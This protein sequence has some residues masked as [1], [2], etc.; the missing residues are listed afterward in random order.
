LNL[1]CG[2]SKYTNPYCFQ[3]GS[4][5][6]HVII[7][8]YAHSSLVHP[9]AVCVDTAFTFVYYVWQQMLDI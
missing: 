6:H 5:H 3:N 9:A 4:H 8:H 2:Y 1:L 7:V